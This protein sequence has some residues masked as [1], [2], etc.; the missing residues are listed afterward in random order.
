MLPDRRSQKTL[1]VFIGWLL[2]LFWC[3]GMVPPING[4]LSGRSYEFVDLEVISD[5]SK[6][7]WEVISEEK[8]QH[9]EVQVKETQEEEEQK[10]KQNRLITVQPGDTLSSI[11][12][13]NKTTVQELIRLNGI[14]QPD[15]IY[16]GQKLFV[17]VRDTSIYGRNLASLSRGRVPVTEEELELL[18]R[19]IHGEARGEDFIGQVAVGAVVLNRVQSSGFPNTIREVIYQKNAFTAVHDRQINLEP[20][21]TAYQAAL[22]AI[23]GEDPT[24]GAVYYY[25]P[26]IATD[27]WIKTRPVIKTIGNHTFSI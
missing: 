11:A 12:L 15:K 26:K 5:E 1:A 21:E 4:E 23:M 20:N 7:Q 27:R 10:E 25:N 3:M 6:S 22:A 17:P 14:T 19:V 8:E 2:P 16:A 9:E 13:R 24:G 18:A